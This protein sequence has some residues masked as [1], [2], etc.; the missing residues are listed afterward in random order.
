MAR[1]PAGA[2]RGA[3]PG[4][5]GRARPAA[6]RPSASARR[7]RRAGPRR[8]AISS[9]RPEETSNLAKA[10]S[11][12]KRCWFSAVNSMASRSEEREDD[13]EGDTSQH[14]LW[15]TAAR[16]LA[17]LASPADRSSR[18]AAS[19]VPARRAPASV[20]RIVDAFAQ[21]L[22]GLEVRH[23]LAGERDGL[24]GL[25]IAPLARRA[26]MQAEAAEAADLDALTLGQRVAHDF[27]D[28]LDRQFDVLRRQMALLRGDEL[29]ELGLRHAA[30]A[31]HSKAPRIF[32]VRICVGTPR[33]RDAA[34]GPC[35]S[36]RRPDRRSAP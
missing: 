7:R 36:T 23:V 35:G 22:A 20:V 8:N 2:R 15:A 18:A 13:A 17:E 14:A 32:L 25:G 11:T 29:D 21:V 10:M 5:A 12:S 19:R 16:S 6:R 30:L 4:A 1:R 31:V 33:R 28:L 9:A 26:E 27:E 3:A 24:A 34:A